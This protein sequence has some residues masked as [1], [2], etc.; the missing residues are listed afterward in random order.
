MQHFTATLYPAREGGY[1]VLFKDFPE[2]LTQGRDM[3]EA[4]DN[5][6]E[7]L[8]LTVD[9]YVKEGRDL[10]FPTDGH[11][12]FEWSLANNPAGLTMDGVLHVAIPAPDAE[13]SPVRVSI[14]FTKSVLKRIDNK[15]AALGM[16]RSGYLSV[17]G[18]GY[19]HGSGKSAGEQIEDFGRRHGLGRK[20]GEMY[21]DFLGRIFR[22]RDREK[23]HA[24]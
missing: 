3:Y 8:A 21:I 15:A 4:M 13:A 19:S 2:A 16:T 12:I 18:L 5:A 1:T 23:S 17:A 14:S 7:A 9:E 22:T 6:R 20:P 24:R 11:K 10:P